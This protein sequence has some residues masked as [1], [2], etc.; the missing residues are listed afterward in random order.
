MPTAYLAVAILGQCLNGR[1][2]VPTLVPTPPAPV[3]AMP[4]PSG[5]AIRAVDLP[6]PPAPAADRRAA[7]LFRRRVGR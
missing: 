2:P 3:V 4:V 7:R 1:C 6:S 5:P